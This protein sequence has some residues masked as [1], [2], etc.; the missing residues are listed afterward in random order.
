MNGIMFGNVHSYDDLGL[1]LS[2]KEVAPPEP[3]TMIV[4]VNGANGS[5]DLSE[6]LTGYVQY[7]NRKL[8]FKFSVFAGTNRWVSIYNKVMTAIHGKMMDVILDEDK[9]Y[10]YHGRVKVNSFTSNRT[11]NTIVVEMDAEPFKY[12]VKSSDEPWL[13]DT[14]SF[15]DGIIKDSAY[16]VNG[17]LVVDIVNEQMVV[18]PEFESN[19]E[20]QVVFKG[21]TYTIM[22]GVSQIYEIMFEEGANELEFIGNGKIKVIFRGG[23]L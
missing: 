6:A 20:M 10:F 1:I 5:L 16:E 17:N 11:L 12:N 13:W 14:F 4:D 22:P 8:T 23:T 21:N 2:S 19:A 15:V 18:C 3:K 9:N 7:K